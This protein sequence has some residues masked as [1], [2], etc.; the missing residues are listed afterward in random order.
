MN[1]LKLRAIDNQQDH[2]ELFSKL[3]TKMSCS[4]RAESQDII[5]K[6]NSL[7]YSIYNEILVSE[8]YNCGYSLNRYYKEA[9]EQS[10]LRC[11]AYNRQGDVRVVELKGHHF[12]LAMLFQPQLSSNEQCPHPIILAF[13]KAAKSNSL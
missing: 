13:L 5:I 1:V 3:I 4:L 7:L 8:K 12:F 6:T 9:F 2:N 10:N 11:V